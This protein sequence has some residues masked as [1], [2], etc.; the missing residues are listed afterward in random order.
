MFEKRLLEVIGYGLDLATEAHTGVPLEPDGYYHF[1]P[2]E[3]LTPAV[4]GTLGAL[5]GHSLL[6][7]AV[8][9]FGSARE[10]EDARRVLRAALNA[11]LEGRPLATRAVASSMARKAAH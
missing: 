5:A 9:R 11:C 1:R 7:L 10:L 4:A 6:G 8:E 2:S 3:G